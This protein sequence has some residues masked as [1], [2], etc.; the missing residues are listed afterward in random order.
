MTRPDLIF[1]GNGPLA[2]YAY[3]I[4]SANFNILFRARRKEDLAVVKSIKT[5]HP[6]AHGVL[7]SFGVMVKSDVLDLFEPEGILNIHPS[8]LPRFR[9]ASPIESAILAGDTSFSVSIMK[10]VRAMDA[11][12]LYHQIIMDNL[13]LDKDAIYRSLATAGATWISEHIGH[14]P[15]PVEQSGDPTFCTKFDK[16]MSILTPETKPSEVLMREIIAYKGFPRSKIALFGHE[17]T[18]LEAHTSDLAPTAPGKEY[19]LL[20]ADGRFL[21]LD[22]VQPAGKNPMD[23]RS[24]LNGYG[25]NR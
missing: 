7:A 15:T 4:L 10:L 16:S 11:S 19:A 18:V 25:R 2:D 5:E 20:C 3:D 24:F 8:L 22:R 12:P 23:I 9:G 17:L 13:P 14:L 21:Y 6:A 1:F